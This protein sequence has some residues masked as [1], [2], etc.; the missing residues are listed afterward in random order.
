[1]AR[2]DVGTADFANSR[3]E[4]RRLL[5][6]AGGAFLLVLVAAGATGAA[7]LL[8]SMFGTAGWLDGATSA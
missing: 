4:W 2:R 6:E 7:A 3:L 1:M 8:R 5:A